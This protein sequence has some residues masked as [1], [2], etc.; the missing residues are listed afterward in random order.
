MERERER[1][2][3]RRAAESVKAKRVRGAALPEA[4]IGTLETEGYEV[5][6]AAVAPTRKFWHLVRAAHKDMWVVFNHNARTN[7]NDDKRCQAHINVTDEVLKGIDAVLTPFEKGGLKR[8]SFVVL[9]SFSRCQEQ[10]AHQDFDTDS[11]GFALSVPLG[12]LVALQDCTT[13]DVWPN[14]HLATRTDE[15]LTPIV[16]HQLALKKGDVLVFRG[17]LVHAGSAY[18]KPNVRLHCYLDAE[19]TDRKP[20]ATWELAHHN[21]N[22]L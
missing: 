4:P 15:H 7:A 13:F 8:S 19:H 17:D 3:K 1:K 11:P 5:F 22:P 21:I 14:S 20:N 16:R 12:V 18:S 2:R 6:H 9:R 10:A